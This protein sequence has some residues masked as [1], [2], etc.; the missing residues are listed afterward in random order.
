MKQASQV[1]VITHE[2]CNW[3]LPQIPFWEDWHATYLWPLFSPWFY[4]PSRI[5]CGKNASDAILCQEI[6]CMQSLLLRKNIPERTHEVKTW[7]FTQ[8]E[9]MGL[10]GVLSRPYCDAFHT[11]LSQPS[12]QDREWVFTNGFGV[13]ERIKPSKWQLSQNISNNG[14]F[15]STIWS[16]FTL[17]STFS[18]S[19]FSSG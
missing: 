1:S 7:C 16:T 10:T 3:L 18:T 2:T 5:T 19:L 6:Q 14:I 13:S 15:I 4:L 12:K 17:L 9:K 8:S 11:L